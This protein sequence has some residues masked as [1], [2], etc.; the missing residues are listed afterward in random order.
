M[1]DRP[2][3]ETSDN[4][5]HSQERDIHASGG[6]RASYLRKQ[7]TANTQ[8]TPRGY[9]ERLQGILQIIFINKVCNREWDK[10]VT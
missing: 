7:A 5:Q 3:A 4:T 2:D 6:I 1:S 9:W 8:F 10:T